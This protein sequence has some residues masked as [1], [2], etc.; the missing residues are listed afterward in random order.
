MF[1]AFI[2]RRHWRRG[3][4]F[5]LALIVEAL[6]L[7][8]FLF[9]VSFGSRTKE[10]ELTTISVLP[11]GIKNEPTR[12]A[13]GWALIVCQTIPNYRVENCR[14]LGESPPGSGLSRALRQA[15]WQFRVRPPRVGGKPIIGAWV[16]IRFDWLEQA[17]D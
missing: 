7:L 4:A 6:F 16:R 3:I 10:R 15:A 13:P 17:K 5:V 8:A 14:Q 9:P 2:D 11:E 12:A 1:P